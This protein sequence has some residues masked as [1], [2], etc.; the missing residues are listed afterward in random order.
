MSHSDDNDQWYANWFDTAYY[1]I[2]YR[3]RDHKEAA[4]FMQSLTQNLELKPGA[5]IL[6]LACGRGRHSMYLNQLGYRVTGVDLSA[7]SIAFAKAEL[8]RILS[9]D[10]SA[11]TFAQ[12]GKLDPSRIEF[13]VHNMTQPYDRSFDA[14]F[15][16][17]TSFGYFDDPEDNL[18]TIKAIKSNLKPQA[19][20]VIDFMNVEWVLNHL[21]AANSKTE[22]GIT[23]HNSRRFENGFI[24]KDIKFSDQGKDFHFT[25]RV[26][27]LRLEDFQSYFHT[28]G[29]ELVDVFGNY[30][31]HAYHPVESPRLIMV[32]RNG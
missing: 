20:G 9:G 28:A 21:V 32:F 6:D 29:L 24:Y 31:L 4:E 14:V 19:Y 10:E 15:N 3:D 26:R 25:E 7:S 17:F 30:Q 27:A 5:H 13:E 8:H 2:L 18:N 12:K 1:H 11:L 16:L 23:F 22:Q